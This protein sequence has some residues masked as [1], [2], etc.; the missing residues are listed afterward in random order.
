MDHA[1]HVNLLRDGIAGPGGTWADLGAGR[2]AFTLAL[3]DLL[4]PG[5]VIYAVDRDAAALRANGDAMRLRFPEV[6]VHYHA[7]DFTQPLDLPPLDG[8]VMANALHFHPESLQAGIV[9][10]LR[11]AL[12]REGCILLAEY[13][14]SRGNVA[15][16]HPVPF[17]RWEELARDAGFARTRLLARRSSR[18]LHEIYSA[19]SR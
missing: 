12:R 17:A 16:P 18:F 14:L 15:V 1:D 9:R 10:A 13:N 3:A 8:I 6:T 7:T 4:G 19:V 11:S 2:G 5:A